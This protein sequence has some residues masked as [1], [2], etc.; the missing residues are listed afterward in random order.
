MVR[1]D[2][3]LPP[4]VRRNGARDPAELLGCLQG[5]AELVEHARPRRPPAPFTERE[6]IAEPPGERSAFGGGSF[7]SLKV[8]NVYDDPIDVPGVSRSAIAAKAVT[9]E[10]TVENSA[11]EHVTAHAIA[12]QGAW[13]W[14][15]DRG[16]YGKC[17]KG[18]ATGSSSTKARF[19]SSG[20]GTKDLPPITI[21]RDSTL[22][23]TNSGQF[24]YFSDKDFNVNVTSESHRGTTFIPAGRYRFTVDADGDWTITIK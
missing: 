6:R 9:L 3:G 24:F 13:T 20:N 21:T 18:E 7:S 5:D 17:A 2:Q 8:K 16:L 12:F 22:H 10:Y 15:V 23:W 19:S 11:V 1:P 14:I 4:D